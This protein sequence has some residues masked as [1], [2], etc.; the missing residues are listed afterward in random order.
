MTARDHVPEQIPDVSPV[1]VD[2]SAE[3][4]VLSFKLKDRIATGAKSEVY[5]HTL[6]D[7]TSLAVKV[8]DTSE[9]VADEDRIDR[10]LKEAES[11]SEFE[12]HDHVVS[13][14]NHGMSKG[15]PWIAMEY[16]V[17]GTFADRLGPVV[18][19]TAMRP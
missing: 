14:V 3:L 10:I 4:D 16:I 15:Q 9:T 2:V 19:V 1:S 5:R 11:W 18:P 8:P 7:G 13:L 17:G 12:G 6:P